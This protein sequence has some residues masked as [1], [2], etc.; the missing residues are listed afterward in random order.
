M[1]TKRKMRDIGKRKVFLF[2]SKITKSAINNPKYKKRRI[3]C[4]FYY[5]DISFKKCSQKV[6]G[7]RICEFGVFFYFAPFSKVFANTFV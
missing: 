4:V 1:G 3:L 2:A 6:K 7:K 5:V